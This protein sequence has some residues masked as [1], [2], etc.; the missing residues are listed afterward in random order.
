MPGVSGGG[1]AGR[2]AEVVHVVRAL[3]GVR[4][5]CFGV[6]LPSTG[7]YRS[8]TAGRSVLPLLSTVRPYLSIWAVAVEGR[9]TRGVVAVRVRGKPL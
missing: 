6:P 7:V 8:P 5:D 1:R 9:G 4:G 2:V 3:E